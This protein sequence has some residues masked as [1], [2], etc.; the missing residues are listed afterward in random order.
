MCENNGTFFY[1]FFFFFFS[2]LADTKKVGGPHDV[3]GLETSG[4]CGT[5][6][7]PDQSSF[8]WQTSDLRNAA[9]AID[10][11]SSY[12]VYMFCMTS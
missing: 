7:G 4:N 2:I 9:P 6:S 8:H 10:L 1:L 3:W 5:V 11:V 12:C